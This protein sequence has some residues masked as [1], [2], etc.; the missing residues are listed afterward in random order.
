[1]SLHR[2]TDITLGVPNIAETVEFYTDF[3]LLPQPSSDPNE[4]WFGTV[5]GGPR[6]LRIVHA[7]VRR[8]LSLGIGAE[9]PDDLGR[10]SASLQRFGVES[11]IDGEQ[12]T[13]NE[14]V[15]GVNVTV[16]VAPQVPAKP[17]PEPHLPNFRAPALL[18]TAPAHPRKLGHLMIASVDSQTTTNFF[19]EGLGFKVSDEIKNAATFMRCSTE[20]HNVVVGHGPVNYTHHTSWELSDVDEIGSGVKTALKDH[21]ERH[22]WGMGRFFVGANYFYYLRDP[23]GNLTEYYCGMDEITEDQV[24]KPGVHE[25]GSLW[26]PPMPAS[27]IRPDDLAELMADSH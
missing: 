27:L 18:R 6:Q 10:I 3:G 4:H 21:P 16:S 8:L 9:D 7:P 26:G 11:R 19:T 17:D 15:T 22:T 14:P 23:A 25:P 24:W 12:L 20:H 1:M 2:L 13:T 5:D